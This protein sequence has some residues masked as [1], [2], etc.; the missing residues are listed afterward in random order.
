MEADLLEVMLAG[1]RDLEPHPFLVDPPNPSAFARFQTHFYVFSRRLD[2]LLRPAARGCVALAAARWRRSAGARRHRGAA[3]R[4]LDP[5]VLELSL[6]DARLLGAA[7]NRRLR[8]PPRHERASGRA[9]SLRAALSSG[10]VAACPL[11]LRV[12]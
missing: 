7:P 8:A 3:Q 6:L 12:F 9:A 11:R 2:R 1:L 5:R 4:L 10:F